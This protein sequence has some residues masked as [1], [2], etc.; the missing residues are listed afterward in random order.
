MNGIPKPCHTIGMTHLLSVN[1]SDCS[2]K[3]ANRPSTGMSGRGSTGSG[4]GWISEL[5]GGRDKFRGG[6]LSGVISPLSEILFITSS[7]GLSLCLGLYVCVG[8]GLV[9]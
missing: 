6:D 9:C 4:K 7:N 3:W 5:C 1:S 2:T 8:S